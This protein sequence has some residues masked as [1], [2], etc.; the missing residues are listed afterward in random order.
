ML[1]IC[2]LA[3]A[4]ILVAMLACSTAASAQYS[5]APGMPG[6]AAPSGTS[7]SYGYKFSA[8]TV[9]I[10]AGAT[11]GATLL[12]VRMKHHTVRGCISPDGTKFTDKSGRS[13]RLSAS[14]SAPAGKLVSVKAKKIKEPDGETVLNIINVKKDWGRCEQSMAAALQ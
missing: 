12:Y 13:F 7:R 5:G 10:G 14:S 9:G 2:E 4:A 1:R 8:K 3:M 6:G 11:A